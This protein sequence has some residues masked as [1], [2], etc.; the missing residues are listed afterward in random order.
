LRDLGLHGMMIAR[1]G[2]TAAEVT[3]TPYR[4][5]TPHTL[6]SLTKSFA[7]TAI[8]FCVQEELLSLDSKVTSFF[9]ERFPCRPCEN[10]D[11]ITVRHLLTM[12][13]GH[14]V[15]PYFWPSEQKP[16]DSF[17]RSYV[18]AEP[19]S[20]FLYN[21]AGSHML[22]YIV[23]KVSGQSMEDF[24]RPRLLEPLGITNYVWERHP[25]GVCKSGVGL[26]LCT[27]DILKFGNFLLAEGVYGGEQ[28]L[29]ADW[30]REAT[31][32][33]V[34]QPGDPGTDWTS[35]YG[36]QFWINAREDSYRADGAFGQFCIVVPKRGLV[37]ACN[38][39][40]TDMGAMLNG[41]FDN[42]IP[43]L[44][45]NIPAQTELTAP[46]PE[47]VSQIPEKTYRLHP[48]PIGLERVAFGETVTM[49]INGREYPCAAGQGEWKLTDFP[50]GTPEETRS[51]AL[52][53][54][55]KDGL[56]LL[57]VCQT[58]TPYV[59]DWHIRFGAD[60]VLIDCKANVGFNNEFSAAVFGFAEG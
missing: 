38:S 42:L 52:A 4:L 47:G 5:D 54:G 58:R 29:G 28:L 46:L 39:G 2:E 23:E 33:H 25:D 3:V 60:S 32:M 14:T 12:T 36:Y 8:G 45:G 16:V 50:D 26:H 18:A 1:N 17:L 7:S 57:R 40:T 15:E 24:L 22:S 56:T 49:T 10:M 43:A 31:R 11:K 30:I 59:I 6:N 48:N 20:G 21:T 53:Y 27:R 19:G 55:V 35:G 9:P 44:E 13:T 34:I 37:I 41:I 51:L